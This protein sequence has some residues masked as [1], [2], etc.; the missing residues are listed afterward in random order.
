MSLSSR[1]DWLCAGKDGWVLF[2][3]ARDGEGRL[4]YLE[5]GNAAQGCGSRVDG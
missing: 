5:E 3:G 1:N 2:K 4:I